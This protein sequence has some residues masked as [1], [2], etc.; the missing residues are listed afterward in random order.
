M[1]LGRMLP[2]VDQ[3]LTLTP[4]KKDFKA[5]Y[6][7]ESPIFITKL[8]IRFPMYESRFRFCATKSALWGLLVNVRQSP[9][10][11]P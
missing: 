1:D 9:V 11:S 8:L 5:V 2:M 4:G 3:L 7:V 10:K 6:P